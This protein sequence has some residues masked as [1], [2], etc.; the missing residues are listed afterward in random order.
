MS[1]ACHND[2]KA[3]ALV[4]QQV[5]KDTVYKIGSFLIVADS[6]MNID[7]I[8]KKE[9]VKSITSKGDTL[10]ND[11]DTLILGDFHKVKYEGVYKKYVSKYTFTMFR[12]N[13]IYKGKLAQPN[14][15]DCPKDLKRDKDFRTTIMEGC[16]KGI[17]FA[18]HYTIVEWFC[19]AECSFMDVVDRINGK[20]YQ[21]LPM[22][23]VDGYYGSK[24]S[25]DSRM[26][27]VNSSLIDDHPDF[28]PGYYLYRE[29]ERPT[30]YEWNGTGFRKIE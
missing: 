21:E 26:I 13:D 18:G 17:N 8:N 23:T 25:I 11:K 29:W 28:F 7:V 24:Y 12:I 19:G 5:K 14:F 10:Y 20:I 4:R 6:S 9:P 15:S 30:I 2:R 22:D 27:I 1:I 16:E 3:S